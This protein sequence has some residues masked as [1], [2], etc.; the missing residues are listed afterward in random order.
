V[1]FAVH[2]KHLIAL[3]VA[4]AARQAAGIAQQP[5]PSTRLERLNFEDTSRYDDVMEFLGALAKSSRVV[6]LTT[7]GKTVEGRD[8]PLAVVGG[9]FLGLRWLTSWPA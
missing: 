6:H 9:Q 4:A 7:F 2:E 1:G 3:L 5:S 8:L